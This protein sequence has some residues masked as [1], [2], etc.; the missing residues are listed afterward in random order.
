MELPVID[1]GVLDRQ[2][3]YLVKL[4]GQFDGYRSKLEVAAGA[5]ALLLYAMEHFYSE[6]GLMRAEGYPDV[7]RHHDL[8]DDFRTLCENMVVEGTDLE[9]GRLVS[10][11]SGWLANHIQVEDLRFSVWRRDRVVSRLATCAY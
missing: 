1:D 11:I 10:N 7:D 4:L 5:K 6:E 9:F 8:H 3:Q 2:H